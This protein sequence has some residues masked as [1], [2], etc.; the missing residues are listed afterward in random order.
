[1]QGIP[2]CGGGIYGL[3]RRAGPVRPLLDLPP[4]DDTPAQAPDNGL[5]VPDSAG[6]D[7][8]ISPQQIHDKLPRRYRR[9]GALT[10]IDEPGEQARSRATIG[11]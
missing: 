6:R 5:T 3:R 11:T 7:Q 9:R 1:M 2:V 4:R 8:K 10:I